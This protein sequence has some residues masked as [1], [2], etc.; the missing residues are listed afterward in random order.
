VRE[1]IEVVLQVGPDEWVRGTDPARVV[2]ADRLSSVGP[3]LTDVERLTRDLA[4][5][6]VGFVTYEAGA[7]F[8]LRMKP[9]VGDLP[10]A[11]FALF[12]PG[13][14]RPIARPSASGRYALGPLA[15]SL[16]RAAFA[17]AFGQIKAHLGSGDTY[18]VNYTFRMSGSF[19]GEPLGLFADLIE[20][21]QGGYSAF[22][23]I[24]D[25]AICSASP[26][27]FFRIKGLDLEARPMKGTAR[28]GRTLD[29]DRRSRDGLQAS[30]KQR[31][32]NVMIVDMV[33]NDLGRVAEVGSVA[34]PDLYT[35]ERY[36][37]VWQMTSTVTARSTA[38]LEAI[39][40]AMHPSASVTGAPKVATVDILTRLEPEPRGVYT[41]AIGHVPPDG[42]ACFSVAIRTAIVDE[43]VGMVEFGIGSG[44]VWDSEVEAEYDE[45][46]LKGSVLGQRPR[47][48]DLLE[49][50]RWDPG[51][52]Y[53]LLDR[54]L[55]RLLGSAEYFGFGADI[56]RVRDALDRAV[57]G[58]DRSMRV[59]LLVSRSGG[60]RTEATAFVAGPAPLTIR[61]A[62]RP[63][64]PADVWLYH[65]TTRRDVYEEARVGSGRAD[66]VILWNDRREATEGTTANLVV[67]TGG[68]RVTP[69]VACG[70]LPGTCRAEILAKGEAVERIVTLDQLQ[71]A[72]RIWLVNSVHGWREAVFE[73]RDA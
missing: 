73:R 63:V 15:P 21:Q 25:W 64:D 3:A 70:L 9:P 65:K 55:E 61:L 52:G 58:A 2:G 36:P 40:A 56:A 14:L 41:G 30:E 28:R 5:H 54:H 8:G 27:L 20:A 35:V 38:T 45:C 7:A 4:L 67:E 60:I 11:W 34:V 6:A 53:W 37:N 62:P 46:V 17:D 50:L 26:E 10:L 16:D 13:Q 23:R 12:E 49:T 48:F 69:P 1:S 72:S 51:D 59:R 18:Q 19:E 68:T 47:P 44:I 29:E 32:E 33:R 24:G 57:A 39:F 71:G 22:I 42:D 43:R 66:E 31:A